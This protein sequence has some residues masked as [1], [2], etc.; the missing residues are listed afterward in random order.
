MMDGFKHRGLIEDDDFPCGFRFEHW[1][2]QV[3]KSCKE[4]GSFLECQKIFER[5]F[6]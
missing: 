6:H 4:D 1:P 3:M 2:C 5:K